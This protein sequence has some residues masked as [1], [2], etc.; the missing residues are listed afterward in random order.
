M[1]S[2]RAG[3]APGAL[4]HGAALG[5]ALPA[6]GRPNVPTRRPEVLRKTGGWGNA[7]RRL[8]VSIGG[9][10]VAAARPLAKNLLMARA[11]S[12]GRPCWWPVL[13][14]PPAKRRSH[15]TPR[16]ERAPALA[17]R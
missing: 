6:V 5:L 9:I 16:V 3:D 1:T 8:P 4:L 13:A 15:L 17:G 7:G 10:A 2:F 12:S 11:R 14:L